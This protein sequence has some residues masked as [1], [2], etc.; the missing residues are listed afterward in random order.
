[1]L[2][3]PVDIDMTTE[4]MLL[5]AVT[6]SE[7]IGMSVL[8]ENAGDDEFRQI[9]VERTKTPGRTY[10]GVA[11]LNCGDVRSL[12][13]NAGDPRREASDRQ[14]IV[15]DTDMPALPFHADIFNTLP[16]ATDDPNAPSNKSVW[17]KERQRLLA[18]AN[19]NVEKSHQFRGG[20]LIG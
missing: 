20:A 12:V 4:Q 10:H 2:I 18:L 14:Y 5:T 9:I 15:A 19:R 11:R 8:R 3:A 7:T 13:A 1:M 6:H 16:R 17:R